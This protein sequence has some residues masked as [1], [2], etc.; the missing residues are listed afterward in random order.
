[1][2]SFGRCNLDAFPM[3]PFLANITANPEFISAIAFTT[4]SASSTLFVIFF[5]L[6]PTLIV[7][8]GWCRYLYSLSLGLRLPGLLKGHI[9]TA[10]E[11]VIRTVMRKE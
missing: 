7:F 9:Q 8:L 1:M 11:I 6:F 5:F 10:K 4:C 2:L 3:E